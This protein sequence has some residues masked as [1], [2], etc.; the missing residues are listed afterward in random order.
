MVLNQGLGLVCS[1]GQPS[2]SGCSGGF[3]FRPVLPIV[4]PCMR[5]DGFDVAERIRDREGNDGMELWCP[6][7]VVRAARAVQSLVM[8]GIDW[9]CEQAPR[10]CEVLAWK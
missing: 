8:P 2:A 10:R 5:G 3:L 6:L 7:A 9:T 4:L 1:A